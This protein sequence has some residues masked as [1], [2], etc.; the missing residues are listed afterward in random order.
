[1]IP[2][3]RAAARKEFVEVDRT[4]GDNAQRCAELELPLGACP[5]D[6]RFHLADRLDDGTGFGAIHPVQLVVPDGSCLYLAVPVAEGEQRVRIAILRL[7]DVA[8][9]DPKLVMHTSAGDE[10]G[11]IDRRHESKVGTRQG[12]GKPAR[13]RLSD[14]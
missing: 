10:G 12:K 8:F 1:M 6:V 3:G 14:P 2:V 5:I 4:A 11:D 9:D 13:N 7:L